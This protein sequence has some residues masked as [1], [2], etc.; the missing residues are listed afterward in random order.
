MHLKTRFSHRQSHYI[1]CHDIL[2]SLVRS[3]EL[4]TGTEDL[5]HVTHPRVPR[6]KQILSQLSRHVCH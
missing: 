5:A 6:V 1:P 2:Y 3:I 4:R